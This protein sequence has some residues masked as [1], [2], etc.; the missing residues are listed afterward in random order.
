MPNPGH[1][2]LCSEVF[3]KLQQTRINVYSTILTW[4]KVDIKILKAADTNV[5]KEYT[6]RGSGVKEIVRNDNIRDR[7]KNAT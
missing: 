1:V 6:T 5:V 7:I 4:T 3:I 2:R